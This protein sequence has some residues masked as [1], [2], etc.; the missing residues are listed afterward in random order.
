MMKNQ[1]KLTHLTSMNSDLLP[2]FESINQEVIQL[3]YRWKIFLQLFDS[4]EENLQLLNKSGATVFELLQK[5]IVDDVILTLS[6]LTDKEKPLGQENVSIKNFISKATPYLSQTLPNELSC[7]LNR[8]DSLVQNLRVHRNK[9]IAHKD[10]EHA[11]GARQLPD[12][13]YDDLENSMEELRTIMSKL[14]TEL[15]NQKTCYSVVSKFGCDGQ[16]LLSVL[17]KARD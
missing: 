13:R 2:L 7:T 9:A 12:V 17:R 5:L 8:L 11:V 16:G 1:S 6:R 4:R 10:I 15:F 14:G 3:S